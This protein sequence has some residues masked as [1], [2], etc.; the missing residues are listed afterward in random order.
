VPFVGVG[1]NLGSATPAHWPVIVEK[2]A[3]SVAA[4]GGRLGDGI[5]HCEH[6]K[7]EN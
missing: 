5:A 3:S 2:N 7:F 4:L 6:T 1:G